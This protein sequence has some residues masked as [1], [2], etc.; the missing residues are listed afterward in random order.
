MRL[1]LPGSLLSAGTPLGCVEFVFFVL[2]TYSPLVGSNIIYNCFLYDAFHVASVYDH[3]SPGQLF[4]ISQADRTVSPTEIS[5]I[6]LDR[7]YTPLL[8]FRRPLEAH[9][10]FVSF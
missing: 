2:Q 4:V 7:I 8:H 10:G 1:C 9:V 6:A 5:R 3:S